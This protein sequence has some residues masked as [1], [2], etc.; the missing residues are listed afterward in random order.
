[1]DILILVSNI[2]LLRFLQV[3]TAKRISPEIDRTILTSLNQQ[4]E[5]SVTYGNKDGPTDRL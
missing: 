3:Q 4:K 2:E 5:L 1:M